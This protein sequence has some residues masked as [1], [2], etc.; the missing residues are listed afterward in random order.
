M[1]DEPGPSETVI[2]LR[3]IFAPLAAQLKPEDEP[4]IVYSPEPAG[5]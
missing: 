3:E 4:A 2:R 5:K 1:A